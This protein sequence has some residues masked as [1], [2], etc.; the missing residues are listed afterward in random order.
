TKIRGWKMGERLV[1]E[2]FYRFLVQESA[3]A[4]NGEKVLF[5][6]VVVIHGLLVMFSFSP[7]LCTLLGCIVFCPIEKRAQPTQVAESTTSPTNT[8]KLERTATAKLR[9]RETDTDTDTHIRI[10]RL[11]GNDR[12]I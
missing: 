1:L 9:S 5:F 2:N 11:K 8:E 4:G 7:K 6:L 10:N 3:T 12:L